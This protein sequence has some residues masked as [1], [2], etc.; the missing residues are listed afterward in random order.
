MKITKW[1]LDCNSKEEIS[2][3]MIKPLQIINLEE[4]TINKVHEICQNRTK[5]VKIAL[6]VDC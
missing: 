6:I 3:P 2:H 4:A 1:S 5:F